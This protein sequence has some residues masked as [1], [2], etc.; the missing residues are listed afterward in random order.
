VDGLAVDP[1][2]PDVVY[3]ALGSLGVYK[4]TDGG[5]HWTHLAQS[6]GAAVV[7]VD[8]ADPNIVYAAGN[9]TGAAKS[10]DG[11]LTWIDIDHGLDPAVLS[12]A[13]D[14]ANPSILFAGTF[15]SGV[16]QSADGGTTWTSINTGLTNLSIFALS[17][18]HSA[19][20]MVHAATYGGGVFDITLSD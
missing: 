14:P 4:T 1:T 12:F 16:Y 8:P 10:T 6:I 19:R 18:E 17:V 5:D 7:A 13:I 2:A 15:G 20:L 3:A 11:G 9:G